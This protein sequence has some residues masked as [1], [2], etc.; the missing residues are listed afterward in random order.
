MQARKRERMLKQLSEIK[1]GNMDRNSS[2]SLRTPRSRS[3]GG[4]N[5]L[6]FAA[7]PLQKTQEEEQHKHEGT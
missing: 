2:E 4:G 7:T 5:Y 1:T 6:W 3:V